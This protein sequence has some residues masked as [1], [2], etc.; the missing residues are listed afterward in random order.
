MNDKTKMIAAILF[1][2][3]WGA[4]LLYLYLNLNEAAIWANMIGFRKAFL[5]DRNLEPTV[6]TLF[7]GLVSIFTSVYGIYR[8]ASGKRLY[9]Y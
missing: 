8:F 4:S 1:M 6:F 2:G 3:A 9:K 7:I 5:L